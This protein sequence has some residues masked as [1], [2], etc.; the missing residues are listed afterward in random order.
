MC[1]NTMPPVTLAMAN[2]KEKIKMRNPK[3]PLPDVNARIPPPSRIA[4]K[5]TA[6]ITFRQVIQKEESMLSMPALALGGG[7]APAPQ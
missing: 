1:S 5:S 7:S 2:S 3:K 4:K 6:M